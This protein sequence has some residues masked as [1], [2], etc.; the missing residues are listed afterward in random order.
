MS[1]QFAILEEK[2]FDFLFSARLKLN[3][4]SPTNVF[5]NVQITFD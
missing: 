2:Y 1:E 3:D 4:S 5:T